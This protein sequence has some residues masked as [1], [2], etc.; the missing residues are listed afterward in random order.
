MDGTTQITVR[1]CAREISDALETIDDFDSLTASTGA[2]LVKLMERPDL[3]CNAFPVRTHRIP[4]WLLY[5]DA[6]LTLL[7]GREEAHVTVPIHDHGTWE[8]LGIYR[9]KIDH[10]RYER[11]DSGEE[12][13]SHAELREVER[14]TMERGETVLLPKP[15]HDIHSFTALADDTLVL[16]VI[17]GWYPGYRRY[18]DLETNSYFMEPRTPV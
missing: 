5:C 10:S 4:I 18:F 1:R 3:L 15:P 16:A 7:I 13:G 6:E 11:L 9:G 14:R 12:A 8:M 2:S 17:P